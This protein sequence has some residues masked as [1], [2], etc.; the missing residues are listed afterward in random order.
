MVLPEL[1]QRLY[2]N[3]PSAVWLVRAQPVLVFCLALALLLAAAF[4]AYR[5]SLREAQARQLVTHTLLV[6]QGAVELAADLLQMEAEH[7]AFLIR[8][9]PAFLA[10]RDSYRATA[11]RSMQQ[12]RALTR[13]NTEQQAR[14][15]QIAELEHARNT[16]MR[17]TTRLA[18]SEGIEA[19]RANFAPVAAGSMRPLRDAVFALAQAES[20]LLESRSLDAA[21]QSAQTRWMVLLGPALGIALLGVGFYALLHQLRNSE[22]LGEQLK[23]DIDARKQAEAERDERQAALEAANK[24]LEAF[25]YSISHDLRA[26]LRHIDGFARMLIEDCSDS[27]AAEPKRYLDTIIASARRMGLLIDDLLAF[28]RLGRQPLNRQWVNMQDLVQSAAGEVKANNGGRNSAAQIEVGELPPAEGDLSLLRQ[29]WTNLLSNAIKY[30]EPR[31]SLA[32]IVISGQRKGDGLHYSVHDN[33][34]GFDM[35]YA[36]KLFGVFQRLHPQDQFEGTGVGLAIVQ[37]IVSRHGGKVTATAEVDQGACFSF[38]LPISEP[39]A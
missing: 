10:A 29:V 35:R 36:D 22:R 17:E 28:S 7:R 3:D 4:L 1:A 24:D 25:S 13:D 19:A 32:R 30:S 12:L 23:R 34:V 38:E 33:G 15:D 5:Q 20:R 31:G 9:E 37:R 6:Q 14:L 27:L 8:G 18:Q 16:R 39:T 11:L 2:P 21:A 26:P